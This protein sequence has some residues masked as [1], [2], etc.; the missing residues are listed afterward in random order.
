MH[1]NVCVFTQENMDT[2]PET[3][4]FSKG[5]PVEYIEITPSMALK[6]LTA[7]N[8]SQSPCQDGL[9]PRVRKEL[10]G[11]IALALSIIFNKSLNQGE[12]PMD[13]KI[14]HVAPIFKKGDK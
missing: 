13:W 14:S 7:L 6:K 3:D 10:K 2:V 11:V 5:D 12:F 9:H 8:P 4:I 1:L